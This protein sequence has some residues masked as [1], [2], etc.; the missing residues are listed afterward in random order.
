MS[1]RISENNSNDDDGKDFVLRQY[2][3][4]DGHFS[5]VRRVFPL[6]V[7]NHGLN[8]PQKFP[9]CRSCHYHERCLWIIFYIFFSPIPHHKR[10]RLPMVGIGIAPCR[11]YVRLPGWQ[12]SEVEEYK[13]FTRTG[14]RQSGR[15]GLQFLY[16]KPFLSEVPCRF[17][18]V[19]HLPCW[20]SS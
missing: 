20:L 10:S 5:L 1:S 15:F 11:A 17:L 19:L 7:C 8:A 18:L 12:G 4:T 6:S 2:E 13:Q 3:D 9:A 16:T 14:V